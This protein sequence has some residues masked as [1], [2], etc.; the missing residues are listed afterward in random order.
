[1]KKVNWI[2]EKVLRLCIAVLVMEVT[3]YVYSG[4]RYGFNCVSW[5]SYFDLVV[6][7]PIILAA[8]YAVF[9]AEDICDKVRKMVRFRETKPN[10]IVRKGGDIEGL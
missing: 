6:G 2:L 4:I 3:A 5:P 10:L 9:H 8:V 1:M 7:Y